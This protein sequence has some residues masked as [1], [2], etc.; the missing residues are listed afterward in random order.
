MH[1]IK[2]TD[3]SGNY[4]ST[5]LLTNG[6]DEGGGNYSFDTDYGKLT[7]KADGSYNFTPDG[8]L[9]N[10]AGS[11]LTVK[12]GYT[13]IDNDGD[14]SN[15][16]E[17]IIN[18]QDGAAPTIGTPSDNLVD[19]QHLPKGSDPRPGDLV[20]GGALDVTTGTDAVD[21]KFMSSQSALAGLITAGL[22]SGGTAL[23]YEVSADG[24]TLTG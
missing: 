16:G 10:P 21:V 5:L 8:S 1:Q 15:F 2:F 3:A 9:T 11:D 13:I 17:Q 19:E 4:G 6:T 18:I 23:S 14:I 22:S 24:Y 7:V 20:V 12:V